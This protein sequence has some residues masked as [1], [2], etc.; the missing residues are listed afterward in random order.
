MKSTLRVGA[1]IFLAAINMRAGL[2]VINPLLP[3]LKSEY[4]LSTFVQSL[5][6][7]IP[8][9][10]FAGTAIA[11]R[12]INRLGDTNRVITIALGTLAFSLFMRATFAI[13]TLL[14]F[15]ISMGIA[16]A[17]LN[18][19]LPVWLKENGGTKS[20]ILTGTYVAIMGTC[21]S[22]SLA[23]AVP[24]AHATSIGWRLSMVPWIITGTIAAIWW[25]LKMP[26]NSHAKDYQSVP[27]FFANPLL[28]N[29]S[30]WA[31]TL[32]FGLISMTF[33]ATSTWGPTILVS[34]GF[35][36]THAAWIVA[37]SNL[38]GSILGIAI[39]QYL[40]KKSDMRLA[41]VALA[42]LVALSFLGVG[43][44]HG[45]RII[46]WMILANIGMAICFPLSLLLAVLRG[47]DATQT[48][49]LSIM[50][51][52]VGYL[53]A[54]FSPTIMGAFFDLTSSWSK[55]LGYV[56]VLGAL[57]AVISWEVGKASKIH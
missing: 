56:V 15:S 45:N 36:L 19:M 51:Q 49:L 52:S 23:I 54:A 22:I 34:K 29:R 32:F 8:L 43:I 40:S 53:M 21:V 37:I 55:A 24:L 14:I 41:L 13:P 50:M 44:D 25:Y 11:M 27:H 9:I 33:Y 17:T 30:A 42:L 31:I 5:F 46:I 20:G 4:H 39:P 18:Y 57:Q 38:I 2:V 12:Y 7:A 35:T 48:R 6:S 47:N 28:K 3:I 10:C 16:I 1:P 26:H